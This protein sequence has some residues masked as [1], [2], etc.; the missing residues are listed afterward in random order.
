V[1][2]RK[3]FCTPKHHNPTFEKK[4]EFLE[5]FCLLIIQFYFK[6]RNFEENFSDKIEASG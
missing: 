4:Y 3:A 6:K 5:L 2:Y 1:I